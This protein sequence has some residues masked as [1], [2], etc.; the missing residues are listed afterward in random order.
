MAQVFGAKRPRAVPPLFALALPLALAL[1]LEPAL[2]LAPDRLNH[3]KLEKLW[4][5]IIYLYYH[6]RSL[7]LVFYIW[8]VVKMLVPGLGPNTSFPLGPAS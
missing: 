1:A 6:L 8:L 4:H 7:C 2:A 3:E 5:L